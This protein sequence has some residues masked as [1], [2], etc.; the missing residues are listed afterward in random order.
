MLA[1]WQGVMSKISSCGPLIEWYI[2]KDGGGNTNA[3]AATVAAKIALML[4]M[5]T[6]GL[7]IQQFTGHYIFEPT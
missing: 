7:H 6:A 1:Q 2:V 3:H 5:A 4:T